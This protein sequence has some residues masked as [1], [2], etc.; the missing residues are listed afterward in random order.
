MFN[1]RD[2]FFLQWHLTDRCNLRCTHC[3][4]DAVKP[5]LPARELTAVFENF[6]RLRRRMPQPRARVQLAGGE[7]L[8]SEHLFHVLDLVAAAGFQSR[9]LTNGTLV[10]AGVARDL[11]AHG[12]RIVQVSVD[13]GPTAHD[14]MRGRGSFRRVM[15]GARHLRDAGIEVTFSMTLTRENRAEIGAV[16]EAARGVARRVGFHRLV[17][18]GR[19]TE[20]A[21]RLLSREELEAAF[22][23][24]L[25]QRRRAPELEV[26]LRDPLWKPFLR[27]LCLETHA[28]G[29]SAGYGGICID[30]DADVYPCRRMPVVV[31]NALSDELTEV[32]NAGSMS[33]LRDRDALRGRCGR[34]AL[35]WRC[36]GC[37]AIARAVHGDPLAEDP[38]CFCRLNA[39][40]ALAFRMASGWSRRERART[41][42]GGG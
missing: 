4:R 33:Q 10:D 39:G 21:D 9:I 24:I 22:A 42:G 37:R 2:A 35:R 15:D 25:A 17:P 26:P 6:C 28:D 12:C 5:E 8:L 11:A 18:C 30:S 19:G 29:C 13:G 31:G 16:F 7:P 40:E 14:A 32:W 27:H 34:C 1:P 36:G 3:Y 38:Q 23:E 20:L 41:S